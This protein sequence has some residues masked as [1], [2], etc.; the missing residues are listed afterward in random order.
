MKNLI[1]AYDLNSPGQNYELVRDAT[2]S[3]GTWYQFQYSLFFVQSDLSPEEAYDRVRPYMDTNDKLLVADAASAYVGD[4]PP[5][6]IA[7]LQKV[8][9]DA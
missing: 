8:W 2:R 6:D 1:I 7:A 3:L 5:A 4:Y 9:K